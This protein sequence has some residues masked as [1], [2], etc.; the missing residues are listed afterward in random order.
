MTAPVLLPSGSL[1]TT[2]AGGGVASTDINGGT[3]RARAVA[4]QSDGKYVVAGWGEVASGNDDFALA[5]FNADGSLDTSFS[6][7]G[8]QTTG[9]A[10]DDQ[11]SA[12]AIQSDGKVVVAGTANAGGTGADFALV[13]YNADGSLDTSFG[14]GGKVVTALSAGQDTARGMV[15]QADGKI[16]VAGSSDEADAHNNKLALVRYNADGSLD[17]TFGTGGTAFADFV[18]F[19]TGQAVALQ[20]NGKI[21]VGGYVATGEGRLDMTVARFNPDGSLDTTFDGDGKASFN[22]TENHDLTMAIATQPDGKVLLA[23]YALNVSESD[24]DALLL[25]LNGDGSLDTGFGTGGLVTLARAGSDQ[26]NGIAVQADGRI[27]LSGTCFDGA[28]RG[29]V[30]RLD[31][32]GSFDTSFDGDGILQLPANSSGHGLAVGPDGRVVLAGEAFDFDGSGWNLAVIR[33]AT[34]VTAQIATGGG[35]FGYTI[36]AG[37]FHDADG[38]SLACV[39]TLANGAALPAWLAFDPATRTF[40]GTPA[41]G[42]FGTWQ[43]KVTASDATASVSANFQLQATTDFIE[44]LRAP[45]DQRWNSASPTGTAAALTYSFMTAA[46]AYATTNEAGTFVPFTAAQKTTVRAVLAQYAEIAGLTFT[47]VSDSGSGGQLRFGGNNQSGSSGYANYPGASP[48]AGDV[49]IATNQT[50]NATLDP[51]TYGYATLLHEIGHALGLKHPGTYD[52]TGG[53][54]PPPYLAAGLDSNLYT[55]MSYTA[56]PKNS[57]LEVTGAGATEDDLH[58]STL[59][60]ATQ[61]LYDVAAIQF[62]YG[63]NGATRSGDDTYAFD[64]ATPFFRTLWDGG[65]NDT[66]SAGNFTEAVKI[67]L[68]PGQLSSLVIVTDQLPPGFSGP[69]FDYVGENNLT[70]AFGT[71]IENARGGS[72]NDT[73]AGNDAGNSLGGGGGDD[74]LYGG[75]GNDLFDWESDARAGADTMVGGSGDDVYVVDAADV[76]FELEDEGLDVVWSEVTY[77]IASNPWVE[78]L[79]LFGVGAA[80]ATG[81]GL[82][83]LMQG[84]AADNTFDGGAG[85]D[86]IVGQAGMDTALFSAARAAYTITTIT[87][88]GIYVIVYGPDGRDVLE[89]IEK[90]GFAGNTPLTLADLE[91]N[92][93][94]TGSATTTLAAG[95][96]DTDYVVSVAN[97]LTGFSDVDGGTL[98]VANL[99]AD[100]GTVT[101]N[102]DGTYTIAP[103][104]NFNGALTF[105]YTVT[106]G[107]GGSTAASQSITFAAV[108]DAPANTVPGARSTYTDT[109]LILT[110]LSVADGDAAS[111]LVNLTATHGVLTLSAVTG[112]A[113]AT[114]DGTADAVLGFSGTL[115][116]INAAL[117]SLVYRPDPGYVG[118]DTLTLTTSDL[119]AAG[120]GGILTD[121]DTIGMT[122]VD[123]ISSATSFTLPAGPHALVL[124]GTANI[125]GTGN[126]LDNRLTGNAGANALDGRAGNDTLAGAGGADTL[127][128]GAGADAMSGGTGNDTYLVDN[129]GDTVL[130]SAGQGVDLVQSSVSFTLGAN[131]EN[132]LLEGTGAI[133]GTGNALANSIT[134]NDAANLLDGGTGADTMTGGLGNDTYV[135]ERGADLVVELAAGG[136][137][138]VRS[139]VTYLLASELENLLLTGTGAIDGTGNA[140]ANSITG[141][142]AANRLDGGA[143]ADTLAGGE[144]ND[145]YMIDDAGDQAVENANQGI[146]LVQSAITFV[147][148]GNFENLTL[149]GSGAVNGTG[150]GKANVLN[151]N[152]AANTLKSLGGADI[153]AGGGGTDKL[154]GGAGNDT[155]TGGNGADKFYFDTA[156]GA[157]NI[158]LVTDFAPGQDKVVLDKTVFG[159]LGAIGAL[160]G[161]AFKVGTAATSLAQRVVFNPATGALYYDA[162]GKGAGA[163]V[164]IATL[165]GATTPLTLTAADFQVVA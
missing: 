10:G 87:T 94:P 43:V 61:M 27:L 49:W 16:L 110:G 135:V 52:A 80:N 88:S 47:E 9:F 125:A 36:P 121:T 15:L 79:V 39:A 84:N 143:G 59:Y 21:L 51:G 154:Y 144:G 54:P 97:L 109:V 145:T 81:N 60:P 85:N 115:S 86:T 63:A 123:S 12:V 53:T 152:S 35:A 30:I 2:F 4:I 136:T 101:D 23:G 34:G 45:G 98:A 58:V 33:L 89:G 24:Y 111:V 90:L 119:G 48:A 157:A 147:L 162:D 14:T 92:F 150:N 95:T 29:T 26:F 83:N 118:A 133:N 137:D 28:S 55:V 102:N 99:N 32:N 122:V 148:G 131:V 22:P 40:S 124:T 77:S 20:P 50:S 57:F 78:T 100:H 93:A 142:A 6:T 160:A 103:S 1:D 161:T 65:G 96:E 73:L 74:L 113:F 13:R 140:L 164:Q 139:S 3:E 71:T 46:P 38:D 114:G 76:V 120:T 19:D 75:A 69:M 128:G 130:E 141:N 106:D 82:A 64:A 107:Q 105:G 62:L 129:A 17:S 158:D 134:G 163:Q 68:V 156:T 149:T 7:D 117:A 72:G 104:A 159:A 165:L 8:K 91:V 66:I 5:R 67:D 138:L 41:D 44:A 18:F 25:R 11:A 70:I 153:V 56:P 132:L 155:L 127:I 116:A 31:A 37:M 151:G 126:S 108:N 146:D 112:L 42:D